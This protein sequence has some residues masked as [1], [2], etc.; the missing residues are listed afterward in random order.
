MCLYVFIVKVILHARL[1]LLAQLLLSVEEETAD[2]P[3]IQLYATTGVLFISTLSK[4][5][6]LFFFFFQQIFACLTTNIKF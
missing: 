2:K 5:F 6:I 4:P 3:M 1:T